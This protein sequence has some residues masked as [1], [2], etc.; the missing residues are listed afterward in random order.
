MLI[1]LCAGNL[2]TGDSTIISGN[3]EYEVSFDILL[4]CWDKQRDGRIPEKN[5]FSEFAVK[6]RQHFMNFSS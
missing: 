6:I 5:L 4:A 3:K 2:N 1:R